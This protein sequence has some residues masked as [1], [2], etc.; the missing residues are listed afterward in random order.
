M[1]DVFITKIHIDKVRHLENLDID[2]SAPGEERK[3]LI[4]TGK[5]GS[6]KT[7]VL[8]S[9][10]NLIF[11]GQYYKDVNYITSPN[12]SNHMSRIK[13]LMQVYNQY[14]PN[15]K[16]NFSNETNALMETIFI[17]IPVNRMDLATPTSIEQ[18]DMQSKVEIVNSLSMDFY[19]YMLNLDYQRSGAFVDK[20]TELL[21]K[22]NM[23]FNRFTEAVRE[24]YNCNDLNIRYS[25]DK[26]RIEFD[27]PGRERFSLTEMSDGYKA[28]LNIYM[29]LLMRFGDNEGNIDFDLAA[30][31]LIDELETHLHVEL[32]KRALPF[33]TKM[34]PNAQFIV[35]TH[36]PFVIT[37]LPDAVVYDLEK[38][39]TLE[40]PS[41]YSYESVVE[42]FLDTGSYSQAL[43]DYFNRYKELS[44]KER[45]PEENEE[46]LRAKTELELMSPASKELYIAFT[47]LE[48]ERKA[49]KNG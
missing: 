15:I 11:S 14:V 12:D 39:E 45:T 22:L 13:S 25:R 37:S 41:L 42:S 17:Y 18:I 44:F 31:V 43:R 7:S 28:L 27:I 6:G 10:K 16:V 26:L 20:N 35:T 24:I 46:F 36:S 30:V 9:L 4:L 38:R 23:W 40:N 49:K 32:Q 33:L 48:K 1:Q 3:H 29:E 47:N 2:L 19:K 5:N 21:G 34:F 8:L